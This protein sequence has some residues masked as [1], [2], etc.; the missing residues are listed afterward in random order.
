MTE[1]DEAALL[2][3]S[4]DVLFLSLRKLIKQELIPE[5]RAVSLL[6]AA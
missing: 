2:T 4:N 6:I 5:I 3:S 1:R